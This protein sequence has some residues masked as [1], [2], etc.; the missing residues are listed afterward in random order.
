MHYAVHG[1]LPRKHILI[2][3]NNI[4]AVVSPVRPLLATSSFVRYR[5][6]GIHSD[7]V[8]STPLRRA[9]G[10]SC[11]R[12]N[13]IPAQ[14]RSPIRSPSERVKSPRAS[15]PTLL[16][17][18]PSGSVLYSY[19]PIRRML[20]LGVDGYLMTQGRQRSLM[21]GRRAAMRGRTQRG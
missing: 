3:N 7:S 8:L 16:L 20:M 6:S 19:Q 13:S 12:L 4:C 5:Q 15:L 18:L 1:S 10:A 2:L 9:C 17:F 11:I 21:T 14:G